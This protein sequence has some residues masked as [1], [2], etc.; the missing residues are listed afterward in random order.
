[1]QILTQES[2]GIPMKIMFLVIAIQ[3]LESICIPMTMKDLCPTMDVRHEGFVSQQIEFLPLSPKKV[4]ITVALTV[5]L[6][7]VRILNTGL[8]NLGMGAMM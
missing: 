3:T 2:I 8:W 5:A 4:L 1:M 7:A 6:N